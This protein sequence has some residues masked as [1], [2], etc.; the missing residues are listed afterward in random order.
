M[1][2]GSVVAVFPGLLGLVNAH[3]KGNLEKSEYDDTHPPLSTS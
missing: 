1:V 2:G 3:I